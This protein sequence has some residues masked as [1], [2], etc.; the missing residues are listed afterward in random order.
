VLLKDL[1]EIWSK[2]K[3]ATRSSMV[4][5]KKT[6]GDQNQDSSLGKRPNSDLS[7]YE[8]EENTDGDASKKAGI[9]VIKSPIIYDKPNGLTGNFDKIFLEDC[10]SRLMEEKFRKKAKWSGNLEKKQSKM[11]LQ[12]AMA[13]ASRV[14]QK[15]TQRN[16]RKAEKSEELLI[17]KKMEWMIQ[18]DSYRE[19]SFKRENPLKAKNYSTEEIYYP[20]DFLIRGLFNFNNRPTKKFVE[21]KEELAHPLSQ[22]IIIRNENIIPF[23]KL[24]GRLFKYIDEECNLKTLQFVGVKSDEFKFVNIKNNGIPI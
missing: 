14:E 23:S 2:G 7:N 11:A 21:I 16:A 6:E 8:I 15:E 13:E 20:E 1:T 12:E 3:K 22:K 10:I 19:S 4:L 17:K 5:A 24:D 18:E 9:S